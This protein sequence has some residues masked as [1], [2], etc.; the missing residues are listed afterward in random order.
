MKNAMELRTLVM[1][2]ALTLGILDKE[3]LGKK[4]YDILTGLYRNALDALTERSQEQP[5]Q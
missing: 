2:N 1:D 5:T 4:D 3:T